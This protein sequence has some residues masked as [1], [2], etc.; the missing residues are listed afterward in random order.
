MP[1]PPCFRISAGML[2]TP[3]DLP[4]FSIRLGKARKKKVKVVVNDSNSFTNDYKKGLSLIQS[5]NTLRQVTLLD[6]FETSKAICSFMQVIFKC[7]CSCSFF[8]RNAKAFSLNAVAD[9]RRR[10]RHEIIYNIQETIRGSE[11]KKYLNV[12][13]D[14]LYISTGNDVINYFRSEVNRTNVYIFGHVRVTI[15]R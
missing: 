3:G 2:S 6:I 12:A 1:G 14:T 11:F 7:S 4:S 9:V 10:R 15:S 5:Q 13:L 8:K